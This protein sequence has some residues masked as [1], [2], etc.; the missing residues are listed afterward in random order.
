M[1][2]LL[3]KGSS[4]R[5]RQI[6]TILYERGHATVAEVQEALPDPPGYSAVRRLV[7]I[8]EEKGQV[9]HAEQEGR[10]VYSPAETWSQ[11]SKSAIEQVVESFFGGSVESAVA[12]LLTSQKTR[13]SEDE[14]QR[15][16]ALI[17]RA[18]T[19]DTGGPVQG[20]A[21]EGGTAQ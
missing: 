9:K 3:P 21:A 1:T 18:R 16:E 11:V 8:L 13:P 15:L 4:R 7:A 6:M 14:L 2:K 5:E 17:Q 12:T 10:Y 19:E 20:D